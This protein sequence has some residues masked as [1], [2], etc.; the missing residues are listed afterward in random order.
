MADGGASGAATSAVLN[1]HLDDGM[2]PVAETYG[3][4]AI[5][6]RSFGTADRRRVAI[7]D[8]RPLA[9]KLSL[10]REG[11]VHVR[12]RSAVG[13]LLDAEERR[14][15][16]TGEMERLACAVAGASRA[17]LFDTTLRHGDEAT[18]RQKLLRE[19]VH[20]VHN[21]Y[22]EASGPRRLRELLPAEAERLGGRRFAIVQVWRP[23]KTIRR[24]PLALA[25]A[26]SVAAADL[27]PCER[28]FP[29]RVGETYR[30]RFSPVHRWYFFP[31]LER[32]EAIVF[33]TYDSAKDGRARFTP[34]T[35]FAD[36]TTPADAP[37][38]ESI[39]VRLFAFF[40]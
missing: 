9:G 4:G 13:D 22:T 3:E 28:R 21:D 34:H 15:V 8:A 1:Y 10:E 23:L 11:F 14:A 39:E 27:V 7:A 33:K 20:D 16:Y 26:A 18:R 37:P 35:A 30:L 29:D 5:L 36:P 40:D 31:A 25:D 12:H 24:D 32:D 38:R 6:T 2:K 19:P 17:V